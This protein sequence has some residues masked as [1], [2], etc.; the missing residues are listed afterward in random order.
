MSRIG[1]LAS[2]FWNGLKTRRQVEV[3]GPGAAADLGVTLADIGATARQPGD[4]PDRMQRMA[5]VFGA[6]AALSKAA[7]HSVQD[8]AHNCAACH[9]RGICARV[10]YRA[11]GPEAGEVEFCPN[12]PAYREMAS[13]GQAA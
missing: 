5:A 9:A 6:E 4:V 11:H 13:A 3:L 12:A 8:M 10:L 2:S 1:R 7:R